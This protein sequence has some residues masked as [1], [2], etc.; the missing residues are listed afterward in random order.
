[1]RPSIGFETRHANQLPSPVN[2]DGVR[3]HPLRAIPAQDPG[4]PLLRFETIAA[5]LSARNFERVY[6]NNHKERR[7]TS[8]WDRYKNTTQHPQ[9][10]TTSLR[11]KQHR[12]FVL[13][14][15]LSMF[16][17]FLSS[18][19][20]LTS[21]SLPLL[22]DNDCDRWCNQLSF[23]PQCKSARTLALSLFGEKLARYSGLGIPERVPLEI[24]W[25]CSCA[26]NGD[27][28]TCVIMDGCRTVCHVA[29]V[30]VGCG[31]SLLWWGESSSPKGD[32]QFTV[33]SQEHNMN[34]QEHNQSWTRNATC[35]CWYVLVCVSMCCRL[36]VCC[37]WSVVVWWIV[38]LMRCLL[39]GS[40]KGHVT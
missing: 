12:D 20:H 33:N 6:S 35:L 39:C 17:L 5:H 19:S 31:V 13:M 26:G 38:F 2:R 15:V 30:G 11:V 29:G 34:P 40:T 32:Q 21:L 3:Q 27:A 8:R 23:C 9:T 25:S 18:L 1:M 14:S 37:S 36:C 16:I 28:F 7:D 24:K 10:K 22:N 4:L